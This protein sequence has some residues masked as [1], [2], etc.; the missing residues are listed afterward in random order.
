M[1][2]D[3]V[4][5]KNPDPKNLQTEI[6]LSWRYFLEAIAQVANK[7]NFPLIVILEDMHWIDEASL[8]TF[9]VIL[10]ALNAEEKRT[11]KPC[12]NLFFLLS[13]RNE[14]ENLREF[15]FNTYFNE[16]LLQPLSIDN[17]DKMI[18]S[19]L[20]IIEIPEKIKKELLIKSEG[21]P[22]YIEEW[23]HSL[24]DNNLIEFVNNKW[25]INNEITDIPIP[26]TLNSL[27][28][29]RIDKMEENLKSL[30]QK[31]SVIGNSFLHSILEAIEMKFGNEKM[32]HQDLSEL[33][34]LDW[35]IKEKELKN[36]DAQYL[37]KH[38]I[39][40]DVVY[41]T[42]LNYNKKIIHKL[43]AEFVEERFGKDKEYFA[44][45]A[46][47]YERAEI[48]NK[49]VEYLEKAGDHAKENYDNK[50]AIEFY[51]KLLTCLEKVTEPSQEKQ[52]DV[53]LKKGKILELIG[54]WDEAEEIC[55]IALELSE[56]NDKMK[57]IASSSSA[58]GILYHFRG[59]Y[60][61]AMECYK[62]QLIIAEELGDKRGIS[63]AV[64]NMGLV[65]A[66]Q[67]NY[68]KAM[69][70]YEKDLTISEKLGNKRGISMAIGNMGLVYADQGNYEKAM[71]CYEKQL[72]MAEEL[73]DKR[74]I[75]TV[76][77][78]MGLVYADQGNYEKAME[79]YEKLLKISE[80][81]GD[82]RGISSAVG[83]MGLIY[84][85]QGNYEKAMMYYEKQLII[86]EE[87]GDKRGISSAVGNMGIIYAD[88]GNYEKAM[89]CYKKQLIIAEELG[90]KRGISIAVGNMGIS[91]ADRGN[92]DQAMQCYEEQLKI[93][94][95]LGVKRG[96][97]ITVGNM[98]I[99]YADQDNDEKALECF[100][101]AIQIDRELDLKTVLPYHLSD[102]AQ[103]LYRIKEYEKAKQMNEKALESAKEIGYDELIFQ[104]EVL[105]EKI[106]FKQSTSNKN[107][108]IKAINNL[109]NMLNKES[110]IA[111]ATPGQ[112]NEENIATLNYEIALM[113]NE[114][115]QENSKYKNKAIKIYKEL[116]KKTPNIEYKD[117]T[118]ELEKL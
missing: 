47:H 29:S 114:I 67:G 64:G 84:A 62:K 66:D 46:N 45:L 101:K 116:Y 69:Q 51:D 57:R 115:K 61:K 26:G 98:G 113:L 102:N 108:Q 90:D 92:Y 68:E 91:Y 79:C 24:I 8:N 73:E 63:I 39:T 106:H 37:F 103:C 94:K 104:S 109:E 97:S 16:F 111:K 25:Q 105:T 31:A 83:N 86:V 107:K 82:K 71:E 7:Q 58:I 96:I 95:E 38:I 54:K 53:L 74:G 6:Q 35:L 89:E 59:N 88:Q 34:N 78:N 33:M 76:V 42:I 2:Y 72:I 20:G 32:F 99:V 43:I 10:T 110:D 49:A 118:D 23:I 48:T 85:D 11:N 28:L 50:K 21:N 15:E 3:D 40:C 13:Y 55:N 5:L 41:E 60:E 80:K 81:L 9:K 12:K 112:E 30:L 52:I 56:E 44:F 22:F 87:L 18:Q 1:K 93:N 100:E 75:S 70:C 19:M 36:A 17:Y 14:F 27:I 65:Y 77:G 4:R 117:K